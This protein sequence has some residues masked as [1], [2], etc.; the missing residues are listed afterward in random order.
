VNQDP[1]PAQP[2]E[3]VDLVFQVAGVENN[4]CKKITFE[5][6]ESSPF[7]IVG[8]NES[9]KVLEGDTYIRSEKTEWVIP[10]HLA[11]D[12]SALDG[13]E[14]VE[15]EYTVEELERK[16]TLSQKFEVEIEDAIADFE[17]Y[18]KDYSFT[19]KELTIEVLNI[20]DVDVE[21]LTLEIPKQ[22]LIEVKGP[23]KVVL[24]DLDSN[25]YGSTDFEATP[26][27]GNIEVKVSY[28]DQVGIRRTITKQVSFDSS[29]F[30][31]RTADSQG[32]GWTTYILIAIAIVVV[33]IIFVN[34][35]RKKKLKL[36]MKNYGSKGE[37]LLK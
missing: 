36:K 26:Q 15:V 10:Y 2:G 27:D 24:G 25:E 4:E 9:V 31:N 28:T 35:R 3:T 6:I 1:Y 29:Y 16:V 34:K 22:E 37:V 11:V 14:E 33:A 17:V 23:N 20:A 12:E 21:A 30:M 32:T 8:E 5:L 19:T 7:T 13:T 18:V